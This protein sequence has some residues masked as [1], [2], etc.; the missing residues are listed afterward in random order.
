VYAIHVIKTKNFFYEIS[1]RKS[2]YEIVYKVDH[3][4]YLYGFKY[5]NPNN[6][7]GNTKSKEWDSK[8]PLNQGKV[9]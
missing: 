1:L 4:K 6:S 3:R 8:I 7:K 9:F 2:F 5:Y